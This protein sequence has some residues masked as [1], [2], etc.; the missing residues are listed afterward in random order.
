ME[1]YLLQWKEAWQ[2]KKGYPILTL[3]KQN[4]WRGL[5]TAQ[6]NNL[7]FLGGTVT[8]LGGQAFLT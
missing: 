1:Y 4:G 2:V 5:T 3:G 6:N 7:N 8:D